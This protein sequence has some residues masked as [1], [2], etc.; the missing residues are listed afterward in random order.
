M[1]QVHLNRHLLREPAQRSARLIAQARLQRTLEEAARV[2]VW[3]NTAPSRPPNG[4]PISEATD[5]EAIHDF[6]VALRRLRAWLRAF[7][8][9]LADTV[10]RGT[11]RRLRDLS[12][13]AGRARDLEVQSAWLAQP[14]PQRSASTQEAARWLADQV[15]QELDRVRRTLVTRLLS[16]LPEASGRLAD[17]LRHY[18]A[19]V[20]GEGRATEPMAA[21][22][23][24]ALREATQ[25]LTR[26]MQ[27]VKRA[28]QVVAA[29]ETRI[30][31]KRL[32]YLLDAFGP[33]SPR[34]S[35]I[36]PQLVRLQHLLGEL[37]DAQILL[38]RLREV[39]ARRRPG[40]RGA[41]SRGRRPAAR[42]LTALR[43][44][45]EQRIAVAFRR[46]NRAGRSRA[47]GTMFSQIEAL[48]RRLEPAD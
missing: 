41:S 32:R 39:Q 8:P 1:P 18:H 17:E 9:H 33:K 48:T 43:K 12:H 16:A 21:A 45:L 44:Q 40:R 36:L 27:R 6:R 47:T 31:I 28:G 10:R 34:T 11:K 35:R 29:H 5:P 7:R 24:R 37:H 22:M 3:A 38:Q 15:G 19:D 14:G 26:D 30:A 23:G 46:A 20:S 25:A 13:L 4:K 42:S 2:E